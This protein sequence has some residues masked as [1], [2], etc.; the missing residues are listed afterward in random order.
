MNVPTRNITYDGHRL[1]VRIFRAPL[2]RANSMTSLVVTNPNN[3]PVPRL[4]NR[5]RG[6]N[7][8]HQAPMKYFT[9]TSNETRAYTKYGKP[10]IKTW[11]P[12]E[13]L[14]LIDILHTPTRRSL[15]E[16]IGS[17]S[18]NIAFPIKNNRT[19]R[20]STENTQ[21]HDDQV[22][23]RICGIQIDGM[24]I[25]DGYYME[26]VENNNNVPAFHSEVGLCQAALNKLELSAE[27]KNV[28]PPAPPNR[29][30]T[31]KN[32]KRR[33]NNQTMGRRVFSPSLKLQK[34]NN[35]NTNNK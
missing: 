24:P 18:L 20:I 17:N 34:F 4:P 3:D 32:R 23:S 6:S 33:L 27:S 13:D 22:L 16:I 2:Y 11:L 31:L 35:R 28:V 30:Q 26:R 10:Y 25:A 21:V 7:I 29:R 8:Y 5:R 1:R 15:A 14:V 19:Y 9:L 12:T